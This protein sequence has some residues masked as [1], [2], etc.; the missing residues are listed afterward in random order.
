MSS[1]PLWEWSLYMNKTL[2]KFN[3]YVLKMCMKGIL[4]SP[5]DVMETIHL[6]LV[7]TSH[8]FKCWLHHLYILHVSLDNFF[9]LLFPYLWNGDDHGDD[10]ILL[11]LQ[12]QPCDKCK[13]LVVIMFL[14]INRKH[15]VKTELGESAASSSKNQKPWNKSL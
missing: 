13:F 10:L 6:T 12:W 8:G 1:F 11:S 9:K 5:H 3:R 14:R 7:C 4:N 15:S 2:V